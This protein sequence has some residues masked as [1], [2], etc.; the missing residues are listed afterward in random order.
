MSRIRFLVVVA[1]FAVALEAAPADAQECPCA[2][3][4]SGEPTLRLDARGG[5][6]VPTA[7]LR[8]YV[9]EG[10]VLGTGASYRVGE[11]LSVRGD[12]TA[13]L[14]RRADRRMLRRRGADLPKWGSE[15][16]LHHLTGGVQLEVS[17]PG[18]ADVEV[19][20]HAGTGVTFLSTEETEIAEG[21][22]FTQ[23][24]VNGGLELAVPVSQRVRLIGRGELYVLPFRAHAPYH[25]KKEV[26]LPFTAGVAV[27]L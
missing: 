16:D 10:L 17:E 4:S 6:A 22:A 11:R 8:D 2:G 23:F 3:E 26:T 7:D 19:R 12:W 24:T 14:M 18:E 27:G 20:V 5:I 21:G 15:T 13:A 25:L 1:A 9:D